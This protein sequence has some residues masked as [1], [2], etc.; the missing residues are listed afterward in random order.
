MRS[1]GSISEGERGNEGRLTS[2]YLEVTAMDR[3]VM[4]ED[5]GIEAFDVDVG[6]LDAA[7]NEVKGSS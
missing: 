3:A 7:A 5:T 4:D 1:L 2:L 6:G